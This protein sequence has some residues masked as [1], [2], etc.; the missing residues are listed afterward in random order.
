MKSE[1]M[2]AK[3]DHQAKVTYLL[4]EKAEVDRLLKERSVEVEGLHQTA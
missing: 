1:T 2:K 4:E 3:E